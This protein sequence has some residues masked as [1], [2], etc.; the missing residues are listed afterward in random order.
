M[1]IFEMYC[2]VYKFFRILQLHFIILCNVFNHFEIIFVAH[3]RRIIFLIHSEFS[4]IRNFRCDVN[5]FAVFELESFLPILRKFYR[6]SLRSSAPDNSAVPVRINNLAV[7]IFHSDHIFVETMWQI[8]DSVIYFGNAFTSFDIEN[9]L[10]VDFAD[11][12]FG[13]NL[14]R[15]IFFHCV[16][17]GL[18]NF[19]VLFAVIRKFC[20]VHKFFAVAVNLIRNFNVSNKFIL[21]KFL[22]FCVAQMS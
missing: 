21:L 16:K 14:N 17:C 4:K 20:V 19:F 11:F 1:S 7:L 18:R 15:R 3:D 5:I 2:A 13:Y 9:F 10:A 12:F 8:T 6:L 22:N